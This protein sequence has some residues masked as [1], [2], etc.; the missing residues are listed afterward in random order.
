MG[1][2]SITPQSCLQLQ[3][4]QFWITGGLFSDQK[5]HRLL[6]KIQGY[7]QNK[8]IQEIKNQLLDNSTK[9]F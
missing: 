9:R 3:M 8:T 5:Q 6:N 4:S 7:F 2:F 1:R